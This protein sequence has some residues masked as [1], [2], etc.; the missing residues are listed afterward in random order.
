MFTGQRMHLVRVTGPHSVDANAATLIL[1]RVDDA[2]AL[3]LNPK[4][5]LP[6]QTSYLERGANAKVLV[7]LSTRFV[8]A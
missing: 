6:H 8:V 4:L 3:D 7:L 2:T 1:R 5:S